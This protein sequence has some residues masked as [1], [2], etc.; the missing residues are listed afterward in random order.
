M[1]RRDLSKAL[2]ATAAGAAVLPAIAQAQ[3]C[4]LPCYARTPAEV[5]AGVVP[6]STSYPPGDLRRYGAD[7]TG[8][9]FSNTALVSACAC[10]GGG[11]GMVWHPGGTIAFNATIVVPNSI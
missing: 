9:T 7:V 3:T 4:T 6:V 2:L 11:T 5:S 10:N 8:A 1:H